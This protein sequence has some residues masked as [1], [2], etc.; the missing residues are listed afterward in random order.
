MGYSGELLE[1]IPESS[2]AAF[3]RTGNPFCLGPIAT[4][5]N[6][7]DVGNGAGI[8]SLIPTC[9]TGPAGKVVGV[10]TTTEMQERA[11]NTTCESLVGQRGV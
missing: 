8:D 7:V 9:M 2:I 1:V 3:A 6:V 11:H 10:D 4:G 5:E